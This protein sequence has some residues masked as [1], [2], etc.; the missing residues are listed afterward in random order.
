MSYLEGMFGGDEKCVLK[1]Q[2]CLWNIRP[3][4]TVNVDSVAVARKNAFLSR[5]ANICSKCGLLLMPSY[6][7]CTNCKRTS[8]INT[9]GEKELSSKCRPFDTLVSPSKLS[10]NPQRVLD[11]YLQTNK[12][13]DYLKAVL[14]DFPAFLMTVRVM[15]TVIHEEHISAFGSLTHLEARRHLTSLRVEHIQRWVRPILLKMM[16]HP[17]NANHLFNRPVD[18]VVLE[19]SDYHQ[20]IKFPMDLGTIRSRLQRGLY[21]SVSSGVSDIELVFKNAISYNSEADHIYDAAKTMRDDL[22]SELIAL[23]EKYAKEVITMFSILL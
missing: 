15:Q 20:K 4:E 17:R 21:E 16:Q 8:S 10:A 18:V 5:P 22:D 7:H 1:L 3:T 2:K 13:L 11:D 6:T 19:L 23:D 12:F 14:I 9:S